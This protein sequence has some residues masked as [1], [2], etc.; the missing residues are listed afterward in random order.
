M[1]ILD[2]QVSPAA[3]SAARIS[4]R[5]IAKSA[6]DGFSAA[7]IV[8]IEWHYRARERRRLLGLSDRALADFGASR[9]DAAVE[10]DKPFWQT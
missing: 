10:G 9:A 2:T 8:L 5:D 7:L 4:L 1:T 3:G 6:L